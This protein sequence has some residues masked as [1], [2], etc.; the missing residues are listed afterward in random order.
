MQQK[1]KTPVRSIAELKQVCRVATRRYYY[2][3][4]GENGGRSEDLLRYGRLE[5][6]AGEIVKISSYSGTAVM[7]KP[8]N[9]EYYLALEPDVEKAW[10]KA[11]GFP[12]RVVPTLVDTSKI[13]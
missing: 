13:Q 8:G 1:Q 6:G 7:G 9:V 4:P 11:N 5:P 3:L 10:Q 2:Y 12:E